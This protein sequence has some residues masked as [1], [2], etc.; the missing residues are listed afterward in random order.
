MEENPRT[1]SDV[2]RLSIVIP[3]FN[4]AAMTLGCGR[5]VLAARP[6]RCELIIVDDAS[7]DETPALLRAELPEALTITLAQNRRFSGAANAG[8]AASRGEIVLLLN[9]D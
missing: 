4:T 1:M 8:V 6:E 2:P 7:T 5:A 9:S 3:T